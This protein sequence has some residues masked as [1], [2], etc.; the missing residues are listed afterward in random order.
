MAIY[1]RN[2]KSGPFLINSLGFTLDVGFGEKYRVDEEFDYDEEL[3]YNEELLNLVKQSEITIFINERELTI[4]EATLYLSEKLDIASN[5]NI[6]TVMLNKQYYQPEKEIIIDDYN[7]LQ[8]E[9]RPLIL[10]EGCSLSL[11]EGSDLIV[12]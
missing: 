12:E 5:P 10:N 1:F 11:G 6:S 2:N 9:G 4:S 7:Q 8:I 3:C